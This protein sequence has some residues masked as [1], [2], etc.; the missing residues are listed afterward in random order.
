MP[1]QT[2]KTLKWSGYFRVLYQNMSKRKKASA[3]TVAASPAASPKRKKRGE[4]EEDA[5]GAAASG[6]SGSASASDF[7]GWWQLDL[8]RT[9]TMEKYLGAMNLNEVAIQAALKGEK[10]VPTRHRFL[11]TDESVTIERRSRMGNNVTKLVYG[12]P[13]V[14]AMSTGEKKM[15]SS[16]DSDVV[17]ISIDMPLIDGIVKIVDTRAV[18]RGGVLMQTLV[19]S[20]PGVAAKSSRTTRYY[21]KCVDPGP[22][23]AVPE[24]KGAKKK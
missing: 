24:K 19:T 10:D 5:A 7:D 12:T 8:E 14:K 9:D 20:Q 3:A 22:L 15:V 16:L 6:G 2:Y 11:V 21:N 4:A 17:K 18:R 23:P 1:S 13:S